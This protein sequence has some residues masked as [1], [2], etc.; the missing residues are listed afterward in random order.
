MDILYSSQRNGRRVR[1]I[2]SAIRTRV[3]ELKHCS[4]SISLHP[5]RDIVTGQPLEALR[6]KLRTA[7]KIV[8][9]Y[10][11]N[12]VFHSAETTL[13]QA[14]AAAIEVYTNDRVSE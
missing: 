10:Q 13:R 3:A 4:F 9:E 14:E 11:Q 1:K 6:D 2:Y 12:P 5:L 7:M 8:L